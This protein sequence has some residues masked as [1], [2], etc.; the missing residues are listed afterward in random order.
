MVAFRNALTGTLRILDRSG[1]IVGSLA[2]LETI[3]TDAPGIA[4]AVFYDIAEAPLLLVK[5]S[6]IVTTLDNGLSWAVALQASET[7]VRSADVSGFMFTNARW[8]YD[9]LGLEVRS[10]PFRVE[11]HTSLEVP[12]RAVLAKGALRAQ[13]TCIPILMNSDSAPDAPRQS[14]EVWT[15]YTVQSGDTLSG[16]AQLSYGDPKRW[17]GIALVNR[18]ADPTKLKPGTL[19]NIP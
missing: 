14:C 7:W 12:V 6:A 13:T 8:I 5:N 18:I 17:R 10:V 11:T 16:I 19:L 4:N 1:K 9:A 15:V 2:E 3:Y